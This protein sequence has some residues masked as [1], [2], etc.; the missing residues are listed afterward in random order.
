MGDSNSH[1]WFR[2]HSWKLAGGN[3]IGRGDGGDGDVDGGMNG[4][5]DG[6][7]LVMMVVM[8]MTCYTTAGH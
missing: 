2:N 7:L 1:S 4:S 6:L 3:D 5:G 8:V